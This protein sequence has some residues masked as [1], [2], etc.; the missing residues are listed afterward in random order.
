MRLSIGLEQR[1]VQKQIL[2]PR[3]I[4][5]MEILQL[6]L[7]ALEER[8][9][10][11][12]NENPLLEINDR[13][14]T[15]PDESNERDD[16]D[17]PTAEEKEMV[18]DDKSSK[19]D[20]ERLDD[21]DRDVPDYFD[22]RP[23]RSQA[24]LQEAGDRKL[25]AM[26]N[27]ADRHVSLQQFLERQ[28]CELDLE[29]D[30]RRLAMRIVTAVDFNGYL[31]NALGDLLPPNASDEVQTKAAEALRVVQSLEPIGVGARDLRECLLLQ[32]REDMPHYERLRR[33]ISDHLQ[34]MGENRL[35]QVQKITGYT[36]EQIDEA[37][38]ELRHLNPKPGAAFT[39]SM[40][41]TVTPDV[42]VEQR[43]DG[44]YHVFMEDGNVPQL[45]ISRYYRQRLQSKDCTP[46][47]REFIKRKI[48]AAQ[49]L[50]DA[51]NQRRSTLTN[52]A[53]SIVRH[54][55]KFLDEGPEHIEPLKMQKVADEVK[56]HVTTVSR[57]VDDKWIQTPRGI[58]PLRGF[59]VGGT[60]SADGEEV[61]WDAIRVKLQEIV[62]NEDKTK[63]YSDED[64]VVRLAEEGLTVARR[65]VTKYRK[66]MD[67]PSSRQRRDWAL[68]E[69]SKNGEAAKK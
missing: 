14:N 31:P 18:V 53:E 1:Q 6:P 34:D 30:I 63:P 27:V 3:M 67:I 58:F 51:I 50:I 61:A 44:S 29:P 26:A 56:V 13:E 43:D 52:V 69:A 36:F 32:L 64:L 23:S 59:F 65:T 45:R 4:Q 12:M 9:D 40:V 49:W 2:A 68:I 55:R 7:Q 33:L 46:E 57:A 39:Q 17:A 11:E 62:D 21:L 24:G 8:I 38:E 37:W 10:Q 54:Q 16:P 47:E 35:P 20:F 41:P 22:E 25:D 5:S 28:L 60:T 15:L 48:N 42:F 66:K 19:D